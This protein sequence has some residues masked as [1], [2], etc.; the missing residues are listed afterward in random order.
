MRLL[1]VSN[2]LPF[3]VSS[4]NEDLTLHSSA[5]GLVSGLTAY[6]DRA[7]KTPS[8]MEY[9]WIGWPGI[10]VDEEP[11]KKLKSK[12]AER[13]AWPVFIDAETMDKFYHGFCNSTIWPLFHY[14]STMV[15][16]DEADWTQYVK[17][18]E[19]FRDAI[20]N[21]IRPGD[22]IWIHDY[23]LMLLPK[24][25]REKLPEL[26]VGFFLHT[27]FPSYD[28]FRTLPTA[29]RKQILDGILGADLIGFHTIDYM[30]HF[31]RC[32]L[33]ILGIDNN[34]GQLVVDGERAV[35]V[36]TFPMSVD[37]QRIRETIKS[38]EVQEEAK[39]LR[40]TLV[41][42]KTVLSLDR[43][44]YTKGIRHRLEAFTTFL[45]QFPEWHRRVVLLLSVV[46]SRLGAEHYQ[47]MKEEIDKL[48]GNI[49]GKFGTIDWTPIVYRY[50]FL[51]HEQLLALYAVSDVALV[52]PLRDGMNLIA[53]EYVA[54]RPD[55]KGVL[56]LSEMAGAA[57]ELGEALIINPNNQQEIVEALKTALEMPETEQI[58]R[59]QVMQTRLERY[60]VVHWGQEFVDELNSVK[61]HQKQFSAKLLDK[62]TREKLIKD[63]AVSESRILFLDYDGTL[64]PFKER[65][66]TA[67]PGA[68]IIAIL[69][70]LAEDRR[71]N[72][73]IVSGRHKDLLQ[74]WFGSLNI[75][76]VAE[77]GAWIKEKEKDWFPAVKVESNWKEKVLP[78]LRSHE[79]RLPG[80]F[81]EEKE[82]SLVW[83]F[84]SADPELA[85]V[86]SKELVDELSYFSENTDVQVL[87]A[88]KSIEVRNIGIDKGTAAKLLLA[89]KSF[90]FILAV[91]DDQ[92]DED[93]FKVLPEKSY[94]IKVGL[95]KSY[96]KFNL[97][98]HR[99][100]VQLL[101]DLT[102][103]QNQ[104]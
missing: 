26:P 58:R 21:T 36:D 89:D 27:P 35:R 43:L 9:L 46:P 55:E 94:S 69:N 76:I 57:R 75:G 90:D 84:R 18:N 61:E 13:Q 73:V 51:P 41:N 95:A 20:L 81:T 16:F 3:T 10:E 15:K 80:S 53:K 11:R 102:K 2:R 42:L 17:V 6:L 44:D 100:V 45:G 64:S 67:V 8:H 32:C 77:H 30:Q 71:N 34:F 65:P 48:V 62:K 72:L 54:S 87:Q 33:R 14:F 56:I 49:N 79:D 31:L 97:R 47:E 83:N 50:R 88:S 1:I 85:S 60:D 78:I 92:A 19:I 40:S 52:T 96:A 39:R 74:K 22:T 98:N 91:G 5:G 104:K 82:F 99:E 38:V 23:Q 101:T 68:I 12:A 63:Y 103:T 4:E 86:R 28:V 24:L 7:M 29:W 66:E 93:L 25:L 70:T 37:Y 59:N